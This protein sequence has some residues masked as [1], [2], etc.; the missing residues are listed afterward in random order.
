MPIKIKEEHKNTVVGFNKSG[1]PLGERDDLHLLI[2][3]AER[4]PKLL[5]YFEELPEDDELEAME[6]KAT[7]H[8]AHKR[9]L[10]AQRREQLKAKSQQAA[11]QGVV[12]RTTNK[13][14]GQ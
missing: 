14:A 3:K 11:P 10:L 1:K 6:R 8:L 2:R 9:N 5:D 12:T 4:N 13:D 7:S